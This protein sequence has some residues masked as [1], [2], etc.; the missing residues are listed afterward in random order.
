[1]FNN[2]Y[3][4]NAVIRNS[5]IPDDTSIN[6]LNPQAPYGIP[7]QPGIFTIQATGVPG[8]H[9]VFYGS[10][11][12]M[13]TDQV[14]ANILADIAR[15]VKSAGFPAASTPA[16]FVAF[17]DHRPFQLTVPVAEIAKGFY[18]KANALQ[19]KSNTWWTGAA[20]Q[21]HDSSMIWNF[22]EYN[23]VPQLSS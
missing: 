23:I 17:G 9:A 15:V 1:M 5:G 14:K 22:T 16:E 3:Y 7:P 13:S 18:A 12:S 20:W 2:S 6:A 19:G 21:E 4:W 8:L 10:A 11:S